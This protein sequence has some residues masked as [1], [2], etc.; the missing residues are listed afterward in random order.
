MRVPL[1][2]SILAILAILAGVLEL[3]RASMFLGA[4]A[5]G[6][7][8]AG[9]GRVLVGAL[10]VLLGVLWVAAGVGAITLRPWAWLFGMIV[11]IFALFGALFALLATLSWEYAVATAVLPAL[12]VWYLNRAPI[13]EAF[14]IQDEVA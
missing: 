12:V 8:P 14:G 5:F 1:G 7:I 11:A 2:V 4:I 13:R 9:D 10:D 3:V 6:P